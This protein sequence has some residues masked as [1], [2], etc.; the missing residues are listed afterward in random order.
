MQWIFLSPH[1][2]D[3]A[4][5]CGGIIWEQV[6]RGAQVSIWT[7]CAAPPPAGG[8]SP[9]AEEL[10]ARWNTGPQ[11][12]EQRRQEDI[13]S[14]ARLGAAA[15]HLDLH[16][17]IY[18]RAPNGEYLYPSEESLNGGLQPLDQY[19]IDRLYQELKRDIPP[20]ARLVCPLAIGNHVDHQLTR[21]AVERLPH[22]LWYYADYPY[23]QRKPEQLQELLEQGWQTRHF[24]ISVSGLA[25]WQASIAAHA[26][27][28]STFWPTIP[29]MQEAI[30]SYWEME[31][32]TNL[33]QKG[34][35]MGLASG[36][37]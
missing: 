35:S 31:N 37:A 12:T 9:F 30:R 29:A 26:S 18:R 14:C 3:A 27:Q 25:A 11:A 32:A 22:R 1:F 33:W 23:V 28:I 6:R 34:E 16:D 17:C 7:V 19:W 5:S 2:D 36:M 24:R 10:H 21:A 15:R 8:L 13:A 4:L 20:R